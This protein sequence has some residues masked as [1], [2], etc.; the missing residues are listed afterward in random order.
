MKFRQL[1]QDF[2]QEYKDKSGQH[3]ADHCFVNILARR[4]EKL[5]KE[6]YDVKRKTKK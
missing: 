3:I 1:L 4:T 2:F 5:I 6:Y